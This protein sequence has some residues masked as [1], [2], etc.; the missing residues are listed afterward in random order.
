LLEEPLALWDQRCNVELLMCT[1]SLCP[2]QL[3]FPNRVV[4]TVRFIPVPVFSQYQII[5]RVFRYAAQLAV[6]LHLAD[7]A[8]SG[9]IYVGLHLNGE[10]VQCECFIGS[11]L[12]AQD[13]GR[14]RLVIC[15]ISSG[16]CRPK[17]AT[18]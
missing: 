3:W 6:K 12:P 14:Q 17:S 8:Y 16:C 13:S 11:D 4:Q 10:I 2:S 7:G 1:N 5:G 15:P 9:L 18:S